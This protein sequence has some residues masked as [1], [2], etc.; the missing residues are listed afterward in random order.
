MARFNASSFRSKISQAQS[1][2]RT[3][4]SQLRRLQSDVSRAEQQYRR[5]VAELER[6]L[7]S[8]QTGVVVVTRTEWQVLTYH[9]QRQLQDEAELHGI[10]LRLRDDETE[11]DDG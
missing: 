1:K 7:R 10:A 5:S 9:E 2:L 6:A 8:A 4:Q 3:A 11:L